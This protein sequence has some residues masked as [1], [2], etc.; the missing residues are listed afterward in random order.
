MP[1]I[2]ELARGE[3]LRNQSLNQLIWFAGNGSFRFGI[4]KK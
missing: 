3:K 4:N 1:S 2:A